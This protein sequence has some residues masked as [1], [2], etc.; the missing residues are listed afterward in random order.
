VSRSAPADIPALT[1][2]RFLAA[3][4]VV[5]HHLYPAAHLWAPLSQFQENGWISVEFFFLL[6]GF[7][8]TWVY[9]SLED[10]PAG[11]SE[12]Y[13]R[14]IYRIYPAYLFGTVL[15]A[16]LIV[17]SLS[18]E[19]QSWTAVAVRVALYGA[20]TLLALQAWWPKTALA[21]NGPTWSLSCEAFFYAMFPKLLVRLRAWPA[22]TRRRAWF[23][24]W[25][26]SA[27]PFAVVDA[28]PDRLSDIWWLPYISGFNPLMRVSEFIGGILIALAVIER[29][30]DETRSPLGVPLAILTLAFVALLTFGGNAV[31]KGLSFPLISGMIF[32]LAQDSGIASR[33]LGSRPFELLGAASYSM[34]ILHIPLYR[35]AVTCHLLSQPNLPMP[36][37]GL[38][39][40]PSGDPLSFVVFVLLLIAASILT[41]LLL[42]QPAASWLRRRA[43]VRL[44]APRRGTMAAQSSGDTLA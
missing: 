39:G 16:P 6:S 3:L 18:A 1:G 30:R 44:S 17:M 23:M 31:V 42:E 34:Y 11:R 22:A 36:K 21:W 14:R 41:H 38:S 5:F 24:V 32:L 29:G 19:H 20:V 4:Y 8:L 13:R 26:L 25:L 35:W 10:T 43:S 40:G 2:V 7:I 33:V 28:L 37:E 9:R 27:I 15:Y 12:F